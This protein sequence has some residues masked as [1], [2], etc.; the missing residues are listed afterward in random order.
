M[1]IK[2]KI[3]LYFVAETEKSNK[4]NIVYKVNIY[5]NILLY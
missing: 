1:V 4:P 2:M 5:L 3:M